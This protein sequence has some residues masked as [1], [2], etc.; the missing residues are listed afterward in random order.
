MA[1]RQPHCS[2]QAFGYHGDESY[3]AQVLSKMETGNHGGLWRSILKWMLVRSRL[4]LAFVRTQ[5][6]KS[7]LSM[8]GENP[9]IEF[10]LWSRLTVRF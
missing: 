2:N 1:I 4:A 10:S 6:Y 5:R 9:A 7:S 3:E 8:W